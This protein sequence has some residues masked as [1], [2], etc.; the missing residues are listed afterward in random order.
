MLSVAAKVG[1]VGILDKLVQVGAD[2][3]AADKA[4][5][6]PL[7]EASRAGSVAMCKELIE[8]GAD[9]MA[10]GDDG[11]SPM[12]WAVFLHQ[13]EIAARLIP[14]R[15]H[16]QDMSD[17]ASYVQHVAQA[18]LQPANIDAWLRDGISPLAL[19]GEAGALLKSDH[20]EA[21]TK[22][23]LGHVRAFLNHN[24]ALLE[25]SP[26]EWP[27][28]HTVLQLASQE[29]GKVFAHTAPGDEDTS[30]ATRP[31]LI[32]WRNKPAFRRCRLTMRTRGTVRS[33]SY[34]KC[35]RKLA[36]AEGN[37]VVVCDAETGFVESTLDVD[38]SISSLDFSPCG[39]KIAAAC[40]DYDNDNYTVKIL[41]S[42]SESAGTFECKSTLTV[43][44]QVFSVSFSPDGEFI[45]AGYG[46][47]GNAIQIFKAQTGEK[48]QSPL[49]RLAL[50]CARRPYRPDLDGLVRAA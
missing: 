42:S 9:V 39:T 15:M 7:L 17:L 43:D 32:F 34:S 11:A 3:K 12:A 25:K 28:A 22:E 45:A 27:V 41:G 29:P 40:N 24:E 47:P 30:P 44:G 2:V 6:T 4:G 18:F 21:A 10:A 35:G 20:I 5:R 38:G 31:P 23:Q 46:Y 49:S 26:S 8:A 33:I 36:R 14:E 48:F 16:S 37:Q 19:K 13:S 50:K 1:N